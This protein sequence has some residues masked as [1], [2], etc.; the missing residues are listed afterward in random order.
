MTGITEPLGE[1]PLILLTGAT[2]YVGGRLLPEL[3]QK[4]SLVRCLARRPEYLQSR[5]SSG[6]EVVKGDMLDRS[7]L[8]AALDGVH[9][10]YYLV[11]SMG[12]SG[13]FEEED[14]QAA[15]NFGEAAKAAG[16]RRIIYLGGL[17]SQDT[18]LSVHLRS[19][20]EVGDVLRESGVQVIEFQASIVIGSGSLSFE[21][22]RSLVE[23]LPIMITPRWV[24]VQAQPIAVKDLLLYLIDAL[25]FPGEG[26]QIFEIGGLDVVSYGALMQEY[27][28]QRGL[29]RIMIPVPVLTPGLSS[30]WLGLV[31]PVF[32]RVGRKLIDSVRYP[33]I[34][35]DSS[36][37]EA[38]DITTMGVSEAITDALRNED[39]EF[40]QS[41]W[42]DALS[43][44]GRNRQWGG[45]RF[46]SRL[47]DSR[48]AHVDLPP[49]QAFKPI[50]S[51]GGSNGWYF[52]DW[53]WQLR[54]FL[55][56]LAGGVGVRRGRR[57]PES[58]YLGDTVDWWRVEAY[59]PN[60]RVL[61]E[62]EMKAPGRAW[63][64]FEVQ[65]DGSGSIIRQTAIFDP[66]GLA[67]L[68][69]WYLLYPLH[70]LVFAGM[71][72]G[73]ARESSRVG[74]SVAKV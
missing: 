47:I 11:H 60:K 51:I 70:N 15:Q 52:G 54:G 49:D 31:T 39:H 4:G 38:F 68:A 25:D 69:Y 17:S 57:N 67:G 44:A 62:A 45:V 58:M 24:S 36:A 30:L 21:L 29:K 16:V 20:R 48:E 65:E 19:R 40:A 59:E 73:I 22:I 12:T 63:L 42:S 41:R 2:G 43:S 14:R 9:T 55:D 35:R 71:L 72:R 66:V 23:R 5:V 8:A 6:T 10:A 46:G 34:V 13:A 74:Q 7:S 37:R 64:E 26:D 27:A 28:R 1:T 50:R 61:F 33:S 18:N 3:E 56:L 53:L 32:A